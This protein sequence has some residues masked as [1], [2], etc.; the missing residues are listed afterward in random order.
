MVDNTYSGVGPMAV[1]AEGISFVKN[2]MVPTRDGTKLAMDIH[3][4]AGEGPWPVILTYIPYRKDDQPPLEG[5]QHHWAQHGYVGARIDCRGT[6]SSEGMNDDEYRPVEMRDGYDVVEWIAAQDWCDGKVA[7]TGGSY[8]GF[9]SVQVA[10]LAPPHLVTIIPWFYTDDRY[11]DDCHYR[12]GAWRCYFDIGSY[13]C[14]MIGMNAMPPYPE[15]SGERWAELWEQR[16]EQNSPYLLT[17]LANQTDGEYWR[18][19]SIR[20]RY[21]DIQASALL[22][23]GW[24]DG[25]CNTPLRTSQHMTAPS[26]VLIGPWNHSGPDC[27]T[28]GPSLAREHLTVRWCDYWLKGI[29][30][31]VMDEPS[32]NVY[33]QTFDVPDPA[34]THTSGYW[35]CEPSYPI[36]GG[37]TRRLA[38]GGELRPDSRDLTRDGYEEYEYRPSVGIASGLWSAGVPYTL[39]G[40]QRVDEIYAANYTSAPL[41]EPLEIIGMGKAVLYVSST[42][43]VMAFVA[44][45]SDVA[46]DGASAQVTIG[47]LNGTRRNSL[48]DPEP[49]APGEVYELHVDLDA[50]AWRFERGHRIRL[51]ISSAD[52]PNLWPTPY[53]GTNRV[54]RESGRASYLELPVV[55]TREAPAGVLPAVTTPETLTGEL[56]P[57]EMEVEPSAAP[58]T[59]PEDSARVVPGREAPAGP[60]PP[61][62]MEYEPSAAPRTYPEV[63]PRIVPWE[64]THD[65]MRDRTGLKLYRLDEVKASADMTV[66]TE[67]RLEVWAD[68]RNPAATTAI[69]QHFR[70]ITRADGTIN[71]DTSANVRSTKDAIH[72]ALDLDVRLNGLP[73]HQRRWVETFKRRLL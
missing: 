68:N 39:P 43:P 61:D 51:S 59:Y 14:S 22:I 8:G 54:Y 50:T 35:R 45:L 56:P 40:E 19:G 10:A 5:M 32:I 34:R 21:H 48:T 65:V 16:L 27:E 62:E 41:D 29:D 11:T 1:D 69:G 36:P 20:G 53:N 4:P 28:P 2:I 63:S 73:H 25:Y 6:G 3:V 9:T 33:M 44:R 47:V 71:I 67:S 31:G 46:P 13:G 30:N 18:P 49:M 7:M 26:K 57:D 24:R 12:G 15:Y 23:G 66:R 58:R 38:L 55:P 17:W 72:V 37:H 64:I 70:T 60:L 42:A 52:F